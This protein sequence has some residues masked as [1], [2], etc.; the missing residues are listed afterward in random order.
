M[1]HR[2]T[3]IGYVVEISLQG[4]HNH[5]ISI[6]TEIFLPDWNGIL[7]SS[8]LDPAEVEPAEAD[9]GEPTD[10]GLESEYP[11]TNNTTNNTTSSSYQSYRDYKNIVNHPIGN[12]SVF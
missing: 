10:P 8:Q 4:F 12:T 1:I 6:T 5:A 2:Y 9:P 7:E 11:P 3:Y